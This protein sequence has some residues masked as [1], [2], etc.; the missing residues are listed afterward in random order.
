MTCSNRASGDRGRQ[1]PRRWPISRSVSRP[2]A[3]SASRPPRLGRKVRI[4]KADGSP[5]KGKVVNGVWTI[6]EPLGCSKTYTLKADA[7]GVG[8]TSS[9][10]CL[11]HDERPRSAHA[12]VP[13]SEPRRGWVS[14]ARRRQVRR[15]IPNHQVAQRSIHITTTPR[16]GGAF[17]GSPVPRCVGPK[18]YWKPGTKSVGQ[19]N[20]YGV[21]LGDGLFD[22]E[23]VRHQLHPSAA[24]CSSPPT[25]TPRW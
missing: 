16:V 5:V 20:T 21:N 19:V 18:N 11:I 12:G 13:D 4:D 25:T 2:S 8:G 6:S 10:E 14:P 22:Q 23:N 9:K 17:Y 7:V 3:R 24:K 15:V 1:R